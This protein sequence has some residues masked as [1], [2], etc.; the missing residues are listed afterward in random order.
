ME[1]G[2]TND[3]RIWDVCCVYTRDISDAVMI[4]TETGGSG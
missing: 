1:S 2:E 3:T 4:K